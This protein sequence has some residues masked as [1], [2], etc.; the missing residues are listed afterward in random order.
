MTTKIEI[1]NAAYSR[2]RISGL[3]VNPTPEDISL[4][5]RRLEN[6]A[7]QWEAQDICTGYNFEDEPESN[8]VHN[9]PRK[10]WNAY[11]SN[12]AG[13]ILSDFGK[14]PNPMLVNEMR[15]SFSMLNSQTSTPAEVLPSRRQPIGSG[16]RWNNHKKYYHTVPVKAKDCEVNT[17]YVDDVN[18]YIEQFDS[19]VDFGETVA[20]FTVEADTGLTIVSSSLTSPDVSYRIKAVGTDSSSD[21]FLRVK[22]VA[23]MSTGRIETR[24]ANFEVLNAD[25]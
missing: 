23:T 1:V 5:L 8:S 12:L 24:F 20:S 3:T 22:I 15:G 6:M 13:R 14:A 17:M 10:W 7:A 2:A 16:N 19:F 25:L 9:I 18:D 4:A 11:E 21:N